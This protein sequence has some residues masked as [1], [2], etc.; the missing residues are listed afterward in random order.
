MTARTLTLTA[1]SGETNLSLTKDSSRMMPLI[2][3][4]PSISH[5][6]M[7]HG[8]FYRYAISRAYTDAI[9]AAGGIPVV[10]PE[11]ETEID[12]L[13][14]RIDGLVL[15]GGGDIDP[16]LF[17]STSVHPK[18][19]GISDERDAFEIAAFHAAVAK[20]LPTL[21]ICRGIQVM[22]VAQGGT[23]HQHLPDDVRGEIGHRQ[24]EQGK[25]RE[26][27]GHP[28]CLTDG[29][30][31]LRSILGKEEIEVNSF[32]HQAVASPGDMLEVVATSP[33]GVIEALWHPGMRFG[34]GVQWH[35][36]LLAHSH[37]DHAALFS[38]LV[39][40]SGPA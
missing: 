32:H 2:G 17:N 23:L 10:L 30:H 24:H 34:L 7:P 37:P 31:L 38:A 39:A 28:V 19:Y 29:P 25:T 26:D 20:D 33:D 9:H 27:V 11:S 6:T 36:E 13:L 35:P 8:M 12:G 3:I 16:A 1:R 22:S 5:D 15:S 21:C 14:D 4:T 18:T 40:A